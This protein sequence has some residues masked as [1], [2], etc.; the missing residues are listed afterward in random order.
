MRADVSE[1]EQG[2]PSFDNPPVNEVVFSV[3]FPGDVI[4]DV[5]VLADYWTPMRDEFPQ[6]QRHPPVP[7]ATENFSP[8]G[9]QPQGV[10]VEFTTGSPPVRYWFLSKEETRLVQV[11]PD[12]F[13]YNWRALPG[14]ETYPR[15]ETLKPEFK[16]R[17]EALLKVLK[18]SPAPEDAMWCELT[19]I[20]HVEASG[21]DA[22]G[23]GPLSR[24]LGALNPDVTAPS[25]PAI[26]DTQLQQ[27]FRIH[28]AAGQ[29]MGRFYLAAV[30]AFRASDAAPIYVITLIARGKPADTSLASIL[31][32]F[33]LGR[34]LI[35]NGFKEA[36]TS[37]MHKLWKLQP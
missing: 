13:S 18:K 31:A 19:Y 30:P 32:F 21:G 11:Q 9:E 25:L 22:G 35:T 28:D 29:P 6:P 5:G 34:S 16:Q 10:G 12:R 26:E 1:G 14:H 15:Y 4:D 27:R 20:N 37:E 33:D 36:T 24:I 7:S 8:P 3:Q 17:Y 23:H 2:T